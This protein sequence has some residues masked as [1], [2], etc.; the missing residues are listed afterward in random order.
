M[1]AKKKGF[2]PTK[3]QIA[4]AKKHHERLSKFIKKH[5]SK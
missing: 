5:A 3:K 1:P 2:K 4:A